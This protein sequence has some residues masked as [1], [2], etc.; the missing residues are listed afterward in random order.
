MEIT[1]LIN[2][3]SGRIPLIKFENDIIT[4]KGIKVSELS[5][6]YEIE[7]TLCVGLQYPIYG[8]RILKLIN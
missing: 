3:L 5:E 6:Y 7:I 1:R 2:W 4:M 8:K